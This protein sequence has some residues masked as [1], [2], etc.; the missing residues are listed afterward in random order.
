MNTSPNGL[1]LIEEFEGFVDHQYRDSVGVPTIG[2]GTTAADISPLPLTCT[3]AQAEQWLV[4]H[5]ASKYEPAINGLGVPL[6]Q[7]QFDALVSLAYNCGPGVVDWQIGRDLRARN[8]A[9]A[10]GD[11]MHYVFAGGQVLQGL[12]NRRAAER[13]LFDTPASPPPPPPDPHHYS[14]YD[15]TKR[16]LLDGKSELDIVKRY[17]VLRA[18]QGLI[19]HPH[20]AELAALR[21]Q[22]RRAAA[23]VYY[24]SHHPEHAP[25]PAWGAERPTWGFAHRGWRFQQLRHR[26]K[27]ARVAK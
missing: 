4:G 15:T 23:R 5:L 24:E 27:G 10:S 16:T 11:F 20:N 25:S 13:H 6:N 18:E 26:Y 7:N 9:A 17:D 3:R 21:A 22:C 1:H 12:V 8:Y 2:F 19:H 14:R